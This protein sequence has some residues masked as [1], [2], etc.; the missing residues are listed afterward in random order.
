ML[1]EIT[2]ISAETVVN[3]FNIVPSASAI[4]DFD[5]LPDGQ[6]KEDFIQ[7]LNDEIKEEPDTFGPDFTDYRDLT[8][9]ML[10]EC[11]EYGV[12]YTDENFA[13]WG[14]SFTWEFLKSHVGRR[15]IFAIP[16]NYTAIVKYQGLDEEVAFDTTQCT[17]DGRDYILYYLS[18]SNTVYY[19]NRIRPTDS[20][21]LK[22]I[23]TVTKD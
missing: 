19:V 18:D 21:G 5:E 23:I 1:T 15:P 2:I 10:S 9:Q 17:I 4:F 20:G 22:F 11:V 16:L 12:G 6:E 3:D 7:F 13:E 8:Y 14:Y